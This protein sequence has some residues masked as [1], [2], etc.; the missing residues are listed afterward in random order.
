VA[1]PTTGSTAKNQ[2]GQTVSATAGG[3]QKILISMQQQPGTPTSTTSGQIIMNGLGNTASGGAYAFNNTQN[4]SPSI[5]SVIPINSAANVASSAMLIGGNK[6]TPMKIRNVFSN[7][8]TTPTTTSVQNAAINVNASPTVIGVGGAVQG[9]TPLRTLVL[10]AKDPN[11]VLTG[12]SSTLVMTGPGVNNNST[13]VN[14]NVA[15]SSTTTNTNTTNILSNIPSVVPHTAAYAAQLHKQHFSHVTFKCL[16]FEE[17]AMHSVITRATEDL[18]IVLLKQLDERAATVINQEQRE[19]FTKNQV[20]LVRKYLEQQQAVKAL[21]RTRMNDQLSKDQRM[22][23]E[24]EYKQ[25]FLD[26]TE[27]IKRLSRY[28]VLQKTFHEPGEE[29]AKKCN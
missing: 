3:G 2:I 29:D 21:I 10:N 16:S 26:K 8:T 18:T 9:G 24:P 22:V 4:M 6:Q 27:A 23:L 19:A 11:V 7:L 28:H 14:S 25:P 15:S 12:T 1:T 17:L 13:L 20:R 5:A